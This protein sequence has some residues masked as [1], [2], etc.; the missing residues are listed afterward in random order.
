MRGIPVLSIAGKSTCHRRVGARTG[1]QVLAETLAEV[2]I[3]SL[4]Q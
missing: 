3:V 4:T 1:A 2:A